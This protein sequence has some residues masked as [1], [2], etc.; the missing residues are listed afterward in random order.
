MP[1]FSPISALGDDRS[2]NIV[3]A[4]LSFPRIVLGCVHRCF[5]I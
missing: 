5:P 3:E 1:S 4:G 2:K